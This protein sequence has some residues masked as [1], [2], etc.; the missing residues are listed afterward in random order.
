MPW[1]SRDRARWGGLGAQ[2]AGRAADA[3]GSASWKVGGWRGA[4]SGA[5]EPKDQVP[6]SHRRLR[7][8]SLRVALCVRGASPAC[9]HRWSVLWGVAEAQEAAGDW[10]G[11]GSRDPGTPTAHSQPP[12]PEPA[13][14][15]GKG[16]V[17][18]TCQEPRESAGS[19]RPPP[20]PWLSQ[21]LV[22][23]TR[24]CRARA[25]RSHSGAPGTAGG[26]PPGVVLLPRPPWSACSPAWI[27]AAWPGLSIRATIPDAA[28]EGEARVRPIWAPAGCVPHTAHLLT[29]SLCIFTVG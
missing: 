15:T 14:S 26:S 25:V 10:C 6:K 22:V 29:V 7:L 27:L 2:P 17:G 18:V 23:R 11:S 4:G 12:L 3:A 13:R 19:G 9:V 1:G 8:T 24:G 28:V 5:A 21:G 20:P 16:R